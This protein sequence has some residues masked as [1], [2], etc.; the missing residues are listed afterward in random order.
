MP[1]ELLSREFILVDDAE[2]AALLGR[3]LGLAKLPRAQ[4]YRRCAVE[5]APQLATGLRDSVLLQ[6]LGELPQ[7][8]AEDRD[9]AGYLKAA[10][11]V[12]TA[13]GKLCAPA[14]LYDPRCGNPRLTCHVHRQGL[15]VRHLN[16]TIL[17]WIHSTG[18]AQLSGDGD[19]YL[20]FTSAVLLRGSLMSRPLSRG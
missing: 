1:A 15:G 17:Q 18:F 10:P 5:A 6:M 2:E 8:R 19:V 7:L 3:L 4:F 13:S 20:T 9:L 14:E 11:F 16:V 12:P